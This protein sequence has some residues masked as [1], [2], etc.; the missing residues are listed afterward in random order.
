M[1]SAVVHATKIIYDKTKTVPTT[2]K[3]H[4]IQNAGAVS[5]RTIP[6]PKFSPSPGTKVVGPARPKG[7]DWPSTKSSRM[8]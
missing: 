3:G 7:S 5:G 6:T 2:D 4:V 8:Y 1:F